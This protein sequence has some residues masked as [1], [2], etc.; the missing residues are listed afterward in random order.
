MNI[1]GIMAF[2]L[3]LVLAL[4]EFA[5]AWSGLSFINHHGKL[6]VRA[7]KGVQ[8]PRPPKKR[9]EEPVDV[10][11]LYSVLKRTC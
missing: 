1:T 8:L 11:A 7:G 6:A 3:A 9:C 10:N 4:P 2:I 5:D